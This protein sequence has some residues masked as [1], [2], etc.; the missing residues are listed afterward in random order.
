MNKKFKR[1]IS[2]VI[3]SVGI[4]NAI[5]AKKYGDLGANTLK[6]LDENIGLN[7]PCLEKL[8][9]GNLEEFKTI[10]KTTPQAVVTTM[11]ETATG[12]DSVT[13][14]W[15]LMGAKLTK[16]FNDFTKEGFPKDLIA[17]F[18]R[19]TKRKALW[20]KEASGTK[21][22]EQLGQQHLDSGDFI[23]Y[24]SVDSTFQIAAHE[25]VVSLEELYKACEIARKLTDDDNAQNWKVSRVIARPFVGSIGNFVRTGNRHDYSLTPFKKT[26]LNI[27]K[28]N[29]FDVFAIGKINDLFNNSGISSY[30][31]SQNNLEGMDITI[32]AVKSN[33]HDFIFTNLV[34]FDSMYGHPRNPQG[35]K[36]ALEAF[37]V[38]LN[39]LINV[40]NDD[41]LLIV[42]ADHGNDPY[43]KGNDHTRENVPLVI[44][45]KHIIGE[46]IEQRKQ[47]GD[48]GQTIL[49]NFNLKMDE[50]VSFLDKI[51]TK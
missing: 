41:D 43:Y 42:V 12:K 7:L 24:T 15:E 46:V 18:E 34:D 4:G 33:K 1:I 50:G 30:E 16:P 19:L 9:L 29:N 47:F 8:G 48:L 25:D 10:K 21:I 27:L 28:D 2:V 23:V 32:E 37:D 22:I 39:E 36:E 17:E 14:H 13:G 26:A 49:D 11:Q 6:S 51:Q 31:Y 38:K 35:Y 3:D 45:N 5:D 44:F 20:C 40:L